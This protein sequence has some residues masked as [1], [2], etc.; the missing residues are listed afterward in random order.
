MN[1]K[2]TFSLVCKKLLSLRRAP[3]GWKPKK[4]R[5]NEWLLT[6]DRGS[7]PPLGVYVKKFDAQVDN[8]YKN[9]YQASLGEF[10]GRYCRV[11][12]LR[13]TLQKAIEDCFEFMR[14]Q[15][16]ARL[17]KVLLSEQDFAQNLATSIF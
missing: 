11:A 1:R 2:K 16:N 6:A 8:S 9:G 14:A 5:E 3:V 17:L 4:A 10:A 12:P 15:N 7:S 13:T